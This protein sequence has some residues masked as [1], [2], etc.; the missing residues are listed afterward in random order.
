MRPMRCVFRTLMT[1]CLYGETS[2]IG[3]GS[4]D[5]SSDFGSLPDDELDDL[6]DCFGDFDGFGSCDM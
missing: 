6:D 1:A 3:Q 4:G 5:E 2:D